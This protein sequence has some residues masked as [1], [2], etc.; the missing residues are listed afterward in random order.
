VL[1]AAEPG[2]E[3]ERLIREAERKYLAA[4]AALS[5]D[6]RRRRPQ[7]DSET[8]ARFERSLAVVDRAI[9]ETRAAARRHPRDPEV[10]QY[11]M[12]AYAKKV[13]LLREVAQ[14]ERPPK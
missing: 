12:T 5:R 7:V 13:D 10:V 9:A 6:V 8:M 1:A 2:G 3:P 14:D 11:M 4:I